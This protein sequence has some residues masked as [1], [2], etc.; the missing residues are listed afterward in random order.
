MLYEKF[1]INGTACSFSE[2]NIVLSS[3]ILQFLEKND[4]TEIRGVAVAVNGSL[5]RRSEWNTH[6]ISDQDEIEILTATQGG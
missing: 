5:V 6:V 2:Q 3:V 1:F 4:L